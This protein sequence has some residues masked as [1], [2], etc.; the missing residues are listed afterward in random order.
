MSLLTLRAFCRWVRVDVAAVAPPL[1]LVP[2]F[3]WCACV[4]LQDSVEHCIIGVTI[5]SQL[6]NE[7]NQVGCCRALDSPP[8]PLVV[9]F[10][11]FVYFIY[12]QASG[13]F[14]PT[15]QQA[16]TTH[17]LTKHRKIASSFRDS[18]LFDIFTLSCNLLKQVRQQGGTCGEILQTVAELPRLE[19]LFNSIQ[20]LLV[21]S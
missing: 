7:I 10:V 11:C 16:D 4:C 5:L 19:I 8:C 2:P 14:F 3:H 9:P 21:K 1:V 17:P 12:L 20:I 13:F 18:S 6:T 15:S